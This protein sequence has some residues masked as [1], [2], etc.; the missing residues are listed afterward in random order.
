MPE[1]CRVRKRCGLHRR[2]YSLNRHGWTECMPDIMQTKKER[3]KYSSHNNLQLQCSKEMSAI[4][5]DNYV[6]SLAVR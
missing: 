3:P 6:T 4:F 1:M 5:G 2:Y